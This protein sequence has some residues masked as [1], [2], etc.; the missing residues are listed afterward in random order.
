M[1]AISTTPARSIPAKDWG[2]IIPPYP[3]IDKNGKLQI[4]P[5]YNWS[6]EGQ[7][8]WQNGC[9]PPHPPDPPTPKPITP[10]LECVENLGGGKFLAHFGYNNPNR[11]PSS[12]RRAR[13]ASRR[14][15][16]NRGQPNAFA[17]GRVADAFQAELGGGAL[18]WSLT[19]NTVTASSDSPRCGGSITIVKKLVPPDDPGRFNLKIDGEVAGG[20][21]AVGDQGT[22]GTIQVPSGSHMVSES[23][24]PGTSLADYNVEIVCRDEG[25][26]RAGDRGARDPSVE[27][28][29]R[30]GS[31]IVCTITN[32]A[33]QKSDDRVVSPV[34]ECVVFNDGSPDVAVL[35]LPEPHRAIRSR[36]PSATRN[37]FAAGAARPRAADGVRVG[38]RRRRLHHDFRRG[39]REPRL[40]A[41]RP[42][43]HSVVG[44]AALHGDGPAAQGRRAGLRPGCLRAP[45]Q[46]RGG[47]DGWRRND[48]RADHGGHG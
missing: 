31:E 19:G 2:D 37:R 14:R 3:Y 32:T 30:R 43:G 44:L 29:V 38:S 7:A 46:R 13:T 27:V 20:A 1:A 41:V 23:G 15:R 17:S 35:G 39:E 12:R 40:V 11:R 25:P 36:S 28:Q 48:D 9:E 4:F 5:G 16:T 21:A 8:I 6:P 47:R 45:G 24:A 33:E 10:I 22:T 34:L 26:T 18:T 42:N